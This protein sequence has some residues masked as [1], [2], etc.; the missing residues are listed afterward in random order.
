MLILDT[1]LT[2]RIKQKMGNDVIK[3]KSSRLWD[4]S[5]DAEDGSTSKYRLTTTADGRF[6]YS[7]EVVNG[8]DGNFYEKITEYNGTYEITPDRKV[9]L[10]SNVIFFFVCIFP[11][12]SFSK[13]VKEKIVRSVEE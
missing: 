9:F 8:T 11:Q 6:E 12:S 3:E 4:V 10:F 1:S 7:I 5:L 2:S 13:Q